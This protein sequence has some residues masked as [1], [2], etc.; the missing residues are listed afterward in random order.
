V[1][2]HIF[3]IQR[4]GIHDGPGIRTTVFFRF[5][6]LR[7]LWCGN[8][9]SLSTRPL[10]SYV[11]QH[12]IGCGACA[13]A[14]PEKA[15][16]PEPSGKARLRRDLCTACGACAEHCDVAALQMVGRRVSVDEVMEVVLRDRDYYETSGGGLTLSGGDPVGQ[17]DFAVALLRAARAQGLHCCVETSGYTTWIVLKR[18]LPLVDLWLY[19]YKETDPH[20]HRRFTGVTNE[21]IVANLRRLHDSGASILM[22]CPMIPQHNARTEHLDG[23]A[24]LARELPRLRGVELL[25]YYDLWRAKLQRLGLKT[26]L[27]ESVKPPTRRTVEAWKTYLRQRGVPLV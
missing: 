6:P 20:L 4:F 27:P 15:L 19:D 11:P 10:L 25:P 16:S 9:E 13:P 1:N 3:D 7:C 17:P 18:L 14:C 26:E 5:C 23:I 2:G 8:P 21:P 22:R 12:C 24:M